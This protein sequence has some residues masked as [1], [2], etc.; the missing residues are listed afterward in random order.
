LA[1]VPLVQGSQPTALVIDGMEMVA[2]P[3][4]HQE[5]IHIGQMWHI[6]MTKR[7]HGHQT[8]H[9]QL[10]SKHRARC[11]RALSCTEHDSLHTPPQLLCL[12]RLGSL[13]VQDFR[14]AMD[15]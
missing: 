3:D 1:S 9:Y 14:K 4:A 2:H 13:S 8:C 10:Q 6:P 12:Q 7:Q 5:P 11:A 15:R